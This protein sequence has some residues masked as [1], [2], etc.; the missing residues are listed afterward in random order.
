MFEYVWLIPL[1]PLIG[2]II[3]GLFGKS[4]KN[5]KVI[6]G[7]GALMVFCSFL[8]SCGILIQL[9]SLPVEERFF[10]KSL[11]TWI[12]AGT[13]KTDIGF[14]I[15]PLS[16]LMIMVVTGVGFLIH[17]YSIGYMHG[18]EGFYRYFTYLNLFT[19]SMLLLVLGSN[20]LLMFVGWEGVGLC[21]YLLIGYYFHKKSAGDA[22]KKA[23]V[24]NRVGDF[25]FLLGTFALFWYLGQN[26]NIWTINFRELSANAHLL[27]VGGIVTVIALCFFLGATGKSAQI[28]LYTWLPDA[29]EGP[30]PVSALIHAAT[31]VTAGVYMIGRLNFVYIRS[32]E[33][34]MIVAVI[35]AATAIFAATIGTAQNDIKR[36]LAY[37]TVSQLGFM[38][39]AMG[40]GAFTAGIFHLMTHAFFKACL[41]LGSGSVIHAMHHALHHA[42]SHDDPQD[43]RNMGG[44]RKAMPITFLT[45]LVSTIAISGIPGFSGFFS[46][47]EIL[48]AAFANPLHGSL[49]VLLWGTGII[50]AGFTAF[51]MFRL[52]FMTFTGECRI[53][54]KAKDHLHE[55]P[56]VITFPLIVLG[57]LAVVGGYVGMPKILGM[58]PNYLEHYL[59]PVFLGSHEFM[60]QQLQGHG[61]AHY[62]HAF[63]FG[64]MGVSV[65]IALVGI[66]IAYVLYVMSPSLPAKFTSAFP[67]LHRAVYNK[68]YVD[69]LY[70]F[71][72]VNPCKALGNFLWKGFDVVVVDGMVNGVAA[73]VKGFGS[74]LRN[75]QT[76]YVHNY[77]FS[78]AVGVVVIVAFYLFR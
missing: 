42:H 14:L 53:N 67:A 38:F 43:M 3:N 29:M 51:Y 61:E 12:A 25:G 7:I 72:F 46:K 5:E 76:G 44:L 50:A 59:E 36:V 75:T 70:D 64:I 19:F 37:S 34:M 10:E 1:F 71:L 52:V 77:A 40:V 57:I 62:S 9:L 17:V 15:D 20:L 30:T 63:E 27:P 69:E 18:E 60:Q 4:I 65:L 45:F 16:T 32:H 66:S 33:T 55:S 11:F 35:G 74:V 49:N 68:W 48:W 21:S 56:F 24:M 22:G 54:P 6:G 13:F 8:V 28:P 39:L 2:V 73:V 78:M 23:F 58:L 26:H 41:F 31:M 47:D